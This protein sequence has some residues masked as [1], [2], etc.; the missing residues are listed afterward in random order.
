MGF[1][2]E[3]PAAPAVRSMAAWIAGLDFMFAHSSA[4][5][6]GRQVSGAYDGCLIS[7]KGNKSSP[8]VRPLLPPFS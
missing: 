4:G 3:L 6:Y 7:L 5:L 8:S 2:L 1:P